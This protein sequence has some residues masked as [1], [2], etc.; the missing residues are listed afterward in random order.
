MAASPRTGPS[1]RRVFAL[2]ALLLVLVLTFGAAIVSTAST[3]ARSAD[4]YHPRRLIANTDVNPY[5]ANVFLS[6]EVEE[7]KLDKTLRMAQDAGLGWLKQQFSWEEIEPEKGKF[8]VP[9]TMTSSWEKYDR[10]VD[11][12]DRYGLQI[13][14]RLDRPP[15]WA[16]PAATSGRGPM[17]NYADYGDFVYAF[18][19]RYAGRVRYI[20]IWNEP[21]LWYEW[22]GVEPNARDYVTLLR[23]AYRR[24]KEANPNVYVL[25]APLAPT[26]ERSVRALSDLDYL[27]QM[28]DAGA[29]AYFDILAANAFGQALPPDDPPDPNVLNFQRVVLL[30]RIMER[31]GDAAKA[32]W[33]N[34]F[35]WNAAP[36]DFSPDRLIWQRVTEQQQADYTIVGLRLARSW[37]WVGVICI[38]YLRHV[39][40]IRPDS[41]EYYFRLVD[42]D[43]TPRPVYRAL[44]AETSRSG[45]T[46][47]Y[48]EESS[49][50][51][52]AAPGWRYE[53]AP[54]ASG[55][56]HLVASDA[57]TDLT[58]TFEG[59]Q[60]DVIV[61]RAPSA[62][63]LYVSIDGKPADALPRDAQ[64]RAFL[65]L[66]GSSER[67]QV[68]VPVAR[69]LRKTAHTATISYKAPGGPVSF[70]AFV[71]SDT[72]SHWPLGA[73]V[74][75]GA[76]AVFI[77]LTML[78]RESR[79]R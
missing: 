27:Q 56:Q 69:Q 75:V 32:V 74:L 10:I 14:A 9:G 45:P 17:Q 68:Q 58:I 50:A 20:Q 31:N 33:I 78:W 35:G 67:W 25:S 65:D 15:A 39:G 4:L 61:R 29:A 55:R 59:A 64:G 52:K 57:S 71:V 41:A 1:G 3:G 44:K 38:W 63:M 37:D 6:Q 46:L 73:V 13:I 2:L 72:S 54:A 76:A 62:G 42:V 48:F 19:S 12:A 70:D 23:V 60:L 36:A 66:S 51:V 26:L 34:E 47:G 28:Y 53:I 43:F 11:M 77:D 79:K 30:R 40:T 24:A 8:F 49:P 22:G 16:R 18:V 5:G 7:W 21:N